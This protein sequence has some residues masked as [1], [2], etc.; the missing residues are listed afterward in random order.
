MKFTI[1]LLGAGSREFGPVTIQDILRNP[2]LSQCQL[3]LRLM[4]LDETELSRTVQFA[5]ETARQFKQ[6][7][8]IQPTTRLEAALE[9]ASF[10]ITSIELD[11][12]HYWTQEFHLPRLFGFRQIYGENGGPG[13]LFHALRNFVP[14]LNIA[15]AM[16]QHCPD[17]WLLN[18][19]NPLTK[20]GQMLHRC[21][22]IK[23]IGLCHGVF[24]GLDQIAF[25]L[26][27]PF[28]EISGQLSGINHFSWFQKL[29]HV[30]DGED[31]YPRLHEA[32]RRAHWLA[33][34]DDLA[35]SRILFRVFGLYPSPGTNHIGEYLP[36]ATEFW[37]SAALQFFYDPRE[38]I[39][40]EGGAT[41][42]Y[43]YSLTT[44]PTSVP[45]HP[46]VPVETLYPDDS[47]HELPA[48]LPTRELAVPIMEALAC[49]RDYLIPAVNVPNTGGLVPGLP[50]DAFVEVPARISN[51][52]LQPQK[53]EPLPEGVLALLR[54]Q[55]SI[56][57]LLVEAFVER[58]R[59]RLLQALLIDPVTT[60]YRN[61]VHLI[62][63]MFKLQGEALPPL[64][65]QEVH[66]P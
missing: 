1:T 57:K 47:A 16:E 22:R 52:R 27:V 63:E 51:G 24:D 56:N 34:W 44:H 50:E 19:T 66:R 29:W 55:V 30:P 40:W 28:R 26:E 3:T 23:T 18:Y 39:P 12:Y 42:T 7:V 61:A 35:L 21:S 38:G 53:A 46:E 2:G 8:D 60:S 62:N 45:P 36:W 37:A 5:R 65:W 14:M 13:G 54:T 9:G 58:S 41:P 15:R 17:A 33:R 48:G 6:T 20:L 11:R 59:D 25:L 49:G 64:E 10:V 4:D 32:E 43:L 31:L